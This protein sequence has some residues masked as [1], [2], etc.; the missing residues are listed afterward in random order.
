MTRDGHLYCFLKGTKA[1]Y[2]QENKQRYWENR[3]KLGKRVDVERNIH[4]KERVDV[5]KNF[6]CI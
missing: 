1:G 5:T 2:Q 6:E 4:K 3:Q